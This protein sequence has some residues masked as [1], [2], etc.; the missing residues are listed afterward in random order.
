MPPRPPEEVIK[1]RSTTA[2]TLPLKA[3][4]ETIVEYLGSARKPDRDLA[5][6]VHHRVSELLLADAPGAFKISNAFLQTVRST[7]VSDP[8]VNAIAWRCHAEASV[9]TGRL[10]LARDAYEQASRR[11]EEAGDT[12][13]LGQ[14]LVGRIGVL[15]AMGDRKD[16]PSLIKK[17]ERLLTKSG[18][19]AYLAKL[20]MNLGSAYYHGERYGEAHR[21]YQRAADTFEA[22]GV[23]DATWVSL[24]LNQG[25]ACTHLFK[26]EEARDLFLRTETYARELKL[27]RLIAQAQYNRSSVEVLRGDFRSALNLLEDSESTF[28][29]HGIRDMQAASLLARAETYLELSMPRDAL[30]LSR[31]AAEIFQQEEMAL[32]AML[33]R[34]AEARSLLLLGRKTE[35]VGIL[36]AALAFYDRER[37]RPRRATTLLYL[38]RAY[39]SLSRLGESIRSAHRALRTFG[40][41]GMAQAEAQTRCALAEAHL[42]RNQL[43][44]AASVLEPSL[45]SSSLLPVGTRL[46]LHALASRVCRARSQRKQALDHLRR[47]ADCLE[48]QRRLIPGLEMRSSVFENQVSVYHDLIEILI[49]TSAPRFSQVFKLV[50]SARARG[51]RERQIA[52][53]GSVPQD[54]QQK[55]TLLGSLVMRL[56]EAESRDLTSRDKDEIHKLRQQVLSLEK[57][58][59]RRARRLESR[60]A[61]SRRWKGGIDPDEVIPLLGAN[62]TLVEFF[63]LKDRIIALVLQRDEKSLRTLPS[64][65]EHMRSAVESLG[66]Q[67]D[68]MAATASRPIGSLDFHREACE[69]DLKSLFEMLI[70]PLSD[71]LPAT[72]RLTIIPHRFLHLVPFECLHDGEDYL[73]ERWDVVRCPTADFLEG[74]RH[75]ARRSEGRVLISGT[76]EAGPAFIGREID[77]VSALFPSSSTRVLRDPTPE[78][79][80]RESPEA[81]ILHLSTHGVFREDNPMFSRLSLRDGAVF[82][83]DVLEHRLTAELVVLSSCN[84]GRV[85]IGQ[86]DDLSGVAHGFLAAGAKRLVSS[87]WRIHDE[88]TVAWMKAFYETLATDPGR[89]PVRALRAAGRQVRKHWNHPFYWGAF[90]IH[91]S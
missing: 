19:L 31:T 40:S 34:I 44:K 67:L 79:F 64:P 30:D 86:G 9:Y 42:L 37:I 89:D 58:I 68:F 20:H 84:S 65:V 91:G 60:E 22:A 61:V 46:D 70:S 55:R 29:G 87:L 59:S 41:L 18:D 80:L 21:A 90:C 28:D 35:A 51:F 81:E 66:T 6:S 36:D 17:A 13:L 27:D 69:A 5:Q 43:V 47:A 15:T 14:I 25:I 3:D 45:R 72:G 62:E 85:F 16:V 48:N 7:T 83:A 88:A 49:D 56:E 10:K 1:A 71:L 23:K 38:S 63:A 77:A 57:D 78:T 73:H 39:L 75:R 50:E 74:R 11:A 76:V 32:D 53:G 82:L 2:G 8:R 24:L 52:T 26:L 33:A 4:P 12:S 54:L